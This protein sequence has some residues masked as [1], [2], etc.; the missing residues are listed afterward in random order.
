MPTMV[1]AKCS[2]CQKEYELELK[3]YNENIKRNIKFYCSNECRKMRYG[4]DWYKCANCG[5]LVWKTRSQVE[6]SL[7]GNVYCSKSCA[8]TINNTLFKSDENHRLYK[9]QNYR[10][11][12]FELY[13]HKCAVCG[14]DDEKR[15][16]EVH[17]IDGNRSNNK[18]DNLCILCPNCH[19]KLTLHLFSLNS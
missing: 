17:H 4:G 18:I 16:L 19:R 2:V 12:A 11:S 14:Y 1:K 9:G 6:R 10:K 13:E 3:R 5:K 15:I 7:T 8:T